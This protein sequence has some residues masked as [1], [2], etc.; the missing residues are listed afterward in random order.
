MPIDSSI[1]MGVRPIQFDNPMELAGKAMSLRTLAGQQQLQQLQLTQ[2]QQQQDQERTLADLYKGNINPD[3]TVN[4]QGLMGAAA[5]QGLGARIPGMQKQFADADKATADVGH[6]GAQTDELRFKVKKQKLDAAGGAINSLLSKPD[7]THDDVISTVTGLV[8]QGI[9][10]PNQG[11]QMVRTLPGNPA[12]L[13]Q[14]LMQKGLEVM[15]ASKRMDLLTPKFQTMDNGGAIQM[16]TVDQLTGQFT[17]GQAMR[18]VQTP[19][20]VA[21]NATTRRGQDLTDAR[22]KD[23]NG[24]AQ[25]AARTQLVEGPDGYMLVDKGTGLARPAATLNGAQ[26][27]GKDSG[28]NDTQAKALLF[29]SRMQAAEQVLSKLDAQ[30]VNRG[31][32]VKQ[33][34]E[35]TPLIGGALGAAANSL[36]A[37]PQQQQVEQAQRDF[38]N[39]VLRRESGA[40]ISPTEFDSAKKQYFPQVGDSQAVIQQKAQ[41][42]QL[43]T[44]GLMA[45]VPAKKRGSINV[46]VPAQQTGPQIDFQ[47]PDD[48]NAILKKHGAK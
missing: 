9:I 21:S 11:S 18:K 48:I 39:A 14:Y 10:D 44:R 6:V 47:L 34:A 31:S 37:S 5:Q 3:G 43:A 36:V 20:S 23:A 13:R 29:G 38:V 35:S 33:V 40:A 17:P 42:R 24:I 2:A 32:V 4:R 19:D 1:A 28:L 45:E 22:A 27:Q 46:D 12:Q 30:G 7:V 41:N 8:Q 26:V 16:G 25:S 15:D